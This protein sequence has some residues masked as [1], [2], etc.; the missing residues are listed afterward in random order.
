MTKT[1]L[2]GRGVV[3][4]QVPRLPLPTTL[5]F[6]EHR[7]KFSNAHLLAL[8]AGFLLPGQAFTQDKA[9][10][11]EVKRTTMEVRYRKSLPP[12]WKRLAVTEAQKLKVYE[13]QAKHGARLAELRAEMEDIKIKQQVELA[14]VLTEE[15]RKQLLKSTGYSK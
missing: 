4:P 14:A 12:G 5:F 7:M 2:R 8:A 9:M 3:T 1:K 13:I 6:Q 10:K 11:P 15:Q